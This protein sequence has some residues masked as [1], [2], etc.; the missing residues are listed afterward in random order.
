[1]GINKLPQ[2]LQQNRKS[3]PFSLE[4]KKDLFGYRD[5]PCQRFNILNIL[6][7]MYQKSLKSASRYLTV[8]RKVWYPLCLVTF[9][10]IGQD[11]S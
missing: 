1:M 11:L 10:D 3:R 7:D 4:P 8:T 9:H 5:P 6:V 2:L